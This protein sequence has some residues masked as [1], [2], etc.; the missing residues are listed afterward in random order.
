MALRLISDSSTA[1]PFPRQVREPADPKVMMACEK[2]ALE[3]LDV[4][5]MYVRASAPRVKD[6]SQNVLY[7]SYS[8]RSITY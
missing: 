3:E 2:L 4:W 5:I 8:L 7:V 6:E 1:C